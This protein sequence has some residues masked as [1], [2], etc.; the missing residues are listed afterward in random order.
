M[1]LLNFYLFISYILYFTKIKNEEWWGSVTGYDTKD[2]N[3]GYA[4]S[5][6]SK[7]ID[8]YLCGK[9]KYRVHY[10]GDDPLKWSENFS[11]CD[12]VGTIVMCFR[13]KFYHLATIT[14]PSMVPPSS[15]IQIDSI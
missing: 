7:I 8:F 15:H 14:I 6:R 2:H 4:G 9:R 13:M 5:T 10:L 1:F 12:P 3:N 11:K